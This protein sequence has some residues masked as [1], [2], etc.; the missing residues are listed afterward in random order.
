MR[1]PD[2]RDR[3]RA[4]LPAP[5]L[6]ALEL[7]VPAE[8]AGCGTWG[9][10][11]C[12]TC[13]RL[14]TAGP[15]ECTDG[16]PLLAGFDEPVLRAWSLGDYH[17]PLRRIVIDWKTGRCGHLR[18]ELV[19]AG[20][21]AGSRMWPLLAGDVRGD[22]AGGTLLVVPAPSGAM[23]RRHGMLVAV[24]LADAVVAGLADAAA[25]AADAPSS[26]PTPRA[27]LRIASVDLLRRAGGPARQRGSSARSR[28]ANRSRPPDLRAP[29]PAGTAV[30]LVDDVLT[31]GATLAACAESLRGAGADVL[32]ALVV[33]GAR[34][35][36]R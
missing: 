28:V 36:G 10:A 35:P 26:G 1:P 9:V 23:R 4:R 2:P 11:L 27:R 5:L 13:R 12:R 33:A 7:V 20:R 18:R 17:G 19:D 6:A 15:A 14:L 25:R 8:C 3:S 22:D 21:L 32:G 29:V 16:A 24:E 34:A 31:T 30:L